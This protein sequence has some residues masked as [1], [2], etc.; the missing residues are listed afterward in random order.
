MAAKYLI[1]VDGGTQSSKVVV[2]DLEGNVVC[3][4]RRVLKPFSRPEPG[5]VEHP[6]D[7]CWESIAAASREAMA[8]FPGDPGDILGVGLCTIRCCKAFL[9]ADGSLLQPLMSWMDAR[10]YQPYLP[11]DPELAYATTSSGYMTHRFTGRFRDS[12]ANNIILQWPI[13]T[14]TWQWDPALFARFNMRP[15]LL[16][17]LQMPGD[18]AGHVTPECAAATGIPQGLP[19]VTTAND[20]AV[21]AL[22]TG[23]LGE[24]TAL[25]S[26]GTYI[27]SMV[28]GRENRKTPRQFWT[29]FA[30]APRR[31]L[32]ESHGIR[33]GMWTLSWFLDLLGPELAAAAAAE[34]VSREQYLE[35]EAEETPAGS[36]GLLTVL[37]WLAP[38]DRP[39]RKGVMLG[40]D[41]RHTRGH[42]YRSILEAIA[43]TMK[44]C[45]DD[46]CRELGITLDDI[47]VS[48]G[49][50]NSPLFMRIFADVF[51]IPASR[52]T[53]AGGA[54]LGAAI[55]AAVATGAYPDL[56]AAAAAMA[57]ERETFAP[58]PDHSAVYGRVIDDVYTH[59]R[60][61]TDPILERSYPIFR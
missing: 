52:T 26:L 45:V 50:A 17:E 28:H 53:S 10:A 38:T 57:S 22:G 42:V 2:Y 8:A 5:I 35:R 23:S 29:N 21:E 27:A 61:A 24:R 11:D 36:D 20:K 1:G 34:G 56:E 44:T 43:L 18:I 19:V 58:D 15:E 14:D 4:G 9:K 39:F 48:G 60:A 31:Y 41:A 47:V 32:Y 40:W 46:M 16:V 55:C 6:G 3:Q 30:C 12:A 51:G 59:I 25:V 33:R 37:D 49:G 54:S 13:D 7:D